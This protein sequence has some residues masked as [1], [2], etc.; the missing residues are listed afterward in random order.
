MMSIWLDDMEEGAHLCVLH[1]YHEVIYLT[2]IQL[3]L[4]DKK[5]AILLDIMLPWDHT[6]GKQFFYNH[7]NFYTHTHVHLGTHTSVCGTHK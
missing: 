2:H 7:K 5:N 4:A 3:L 6:Y 1:V